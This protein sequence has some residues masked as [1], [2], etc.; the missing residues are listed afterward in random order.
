M[1]I[2]NRLSILFL[3]VFFG[4][5]AVRCTAL[6]NID[7]GWKGVRQS[8]LSGL[9]DHVHDAGY[10]WNI[11]FVHTV[12][13]VPGY[14]RFMNYRGR[15]RLRFRTK[16]NN[17]LGVDVTIPY[18]IKPGMHSKA[19]A[20]GYLSSTGDGRYK[21]DD[22]AEQ[23]ANEIL[24]KVLAQGSIQDFYNTDNRLVLAEKATAALNEK[25]AQWHLE[26]SG[27]LIRY[28]EFP[29]ENERQLA[30]IQLNEVKKLLDDVKKTVAGKQQAL[31]NFNTETSAQLQAKAFEWARRVSDLER[32]YNVGVIDTGDD[33]TPG[34]VRRVLESL[35]PDDLAELRKKAG[36][37]LGIPEDEITEA[38]VTTAHL[39]GIS[40]IK[41]E[42]AEYKARVEAEAFGTEER[43][44][45]EGEQLLAEI[46]AEF[47]RSLNKVLSGQGGAG[48]VA[49][50]AAKNIKFASELTFKSDEVPFIYRLAEFADQLMGK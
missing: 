22:M 26:T 49:F 4:A 35:K 9:S 8:H 47:E 29:A 38:N 15:S 19:V 31:D 11:P 10:M 16:D 24:R 44:I 17:K 40:N 1:K 42:T 39:V 34:A 46:Q 6:N 48:Y 12:W 3:V 2:L 27:V 5:I 20:K 7:K 37:A 30:Q 25:L 21:F 32:A 45:A 13:E 41:A 43:L 36:Q 18:R 50:N 23:T 33:N 14:Y 28:V